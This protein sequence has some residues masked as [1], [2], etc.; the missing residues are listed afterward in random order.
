MSRGLSPT[1]LFVWRYTQM[2]EN[3]NATCSICG[4]AYHL[5]L[6]CSDTMKLRPWKTYTD[7]QECFKVFQVVR[8]F[9]T[10][11]YTKE[12]A[13][14]KLQNVDLKDINSF[15]PHIKKIV[16][17]ILKEEKAVVKAAKKLKNAVVD[18][19]A[20]IKIAETGVVETITDVVELTVSRERNYEVEE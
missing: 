2:V 13:K 4:K 10:G 14:E 5:C 11:V 7:T 6:S 15:R 12:E 18:N 8:G 16:K 19:V 3:N 1:L 20:E 17:D 9:S